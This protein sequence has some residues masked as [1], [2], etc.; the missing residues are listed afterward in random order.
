MRL[1]NELN[2][3]IQQAF[4]KSTV[5]AALFLA[6]MPFLYSQSSQ[7]RIVD[8][9]SSQPVSYATV[10]FVDLD[11]KTEYFKISD[12]EGI[13]VN[14]CKNIALIK[15][16]CIGYTA[17]TDT[18]AAGKS[19]DLS[20][21]P[22]IFSL[23]EVVVT[24]NLKPQRADK[25]I[26]NIKV[27]GQKK[28]EEQGAN[29]LKDLLTNQVNLSISQDPALGSSLKIKGL[30]GN[31]VKILVDGVP[32][33]GRMGSNIDLTQLNLYN[34][35][36]VEMVEGPMSVIYGSDALAGAINIITKEN[37]NSNF[38]FTTNAYYE[39]AGTYNIDGNINFRKKRHSVSV[40]AGRNFFDGY[41]TDT[42]RSQAWKPKE[43]YNADL[44]YLY[45][46][47][48]QIPGL[49]YE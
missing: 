15:V 38:G 34:I 5:L 18:L 31:N 20:M 42:L 28:I 1:N 7:V 39:T 25:S 45:A 35:D 14:P 26:Y 22:T 41:S 44:Y 43:Q 13:V 49:L 40:S 17:L 36:H 46:H 24:G 23:D 3:I 47:E 6:I 16:S 30:T 29:N 48:D 27:V 32:V 37:R 10:L 2:P 8:S 9:K 11:S 4:K 12:E 19:Y 33:I 21:V